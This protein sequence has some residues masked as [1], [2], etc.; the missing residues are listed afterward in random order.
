ME[1]IYGGVLESGMMRK[2]CR[3]EGRRCRREIV[4]DKKGVGKKE[5]VWPSMLYYN[6]K[7]RTVQYVAC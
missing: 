4:Y 1:G 3:N 7:D 2:G 6:F 5:R